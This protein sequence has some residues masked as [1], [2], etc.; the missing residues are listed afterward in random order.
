MNAIIKK[1]LW[2]EFQELKWETLAAT[3]IVLTLPVCLAFRD[4]NLA[5]MTI[6]PNIWL[7][8]ILAGVFFGAR[9]A[10]GERTGRTASFVAAL[11]VAHKLLGM[12]RL[13]AV[14]LALM[15]P[16]SVLGVLA[17]FLNSLVDESS[18]MQSPWLSG[19]FLLDLLA[20][21]FCVATAA[22]AGRGQATEM[23]AGLAGFAAVLATLMVC[24]FLLLVVLA[25]LQEQYEQPP[26]SAGSA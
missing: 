14:F 20:T 10:A 19:I 2:K 1:L 6:V 16:L 26:L 21:F 25:F 3:A 9:A 11:P 12:V 4:A 18:R 13:A 17:I 24:G 22:R 8:P 23:R 7:Y 5:L 15:V